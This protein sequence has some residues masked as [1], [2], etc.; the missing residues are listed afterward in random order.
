M[1]ND[2]KAL[3]QLVAKI[4]INQ[5]K[6]KVNMR[7]DLKFGKKLDHNYDVVYYE[8]KIG[9][10]AWDLHVVEVKC[11]TKSNVPEHDINHFLGK[12]GD[13]KIP[14]SNASFY[15]LTDYSFKARVKASNVGLK[16]FT[17]TDLELNYRK[18]PRKYKRVLKSL[19]K[20]ELKL[21]NKITK[22]L[23]DKKRRLRN[24]LDQLRSAYKLKDFWR[25]YN[26]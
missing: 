25:E 1:K 13:N 17:G 11:Y 4:L 16:L 19:K 18:T 24:E 21:E 7:Y 3:E 6:H 23:L 10:L 12:I 22:N 26:G 20:I 14:I 9:P 15:S 8:H 5:G 2:G